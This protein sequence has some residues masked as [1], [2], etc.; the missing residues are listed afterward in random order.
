MVLVAGCAT[1]VGPVPGGAPVDRADGVRA[2]SEAGGPA[3]RAGVAFEDEPYYHA[4]PLYGVVLRDADE[5]LPVFAS[6]DGDHGFL[7]YLPP[8]GG[9]ITGT[10]RERVVEHTRYVEVL[11]PDGPGSGWVDSRYLTEWVSPDRFCRATAEEQHVEETLFTLERALAS[12][13]GA[14]L[15]DVASPRGLFVR[16]RDDAEAALLS[17]HDMRAGTLEDGMT[18]ELL[19]LLGDGDAEGHCNRVVAGGSTGA[20]FPTGYINFNFLTLHTESDEGAISWLVVFEHVD[21][22]PKLVALERLR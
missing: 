21:G 1:E 19:E 10:G 16:G 5:P 2:P 12:D 4:E 18:A 11:L 14:S 3:A 15:A 20:S 6:P 13:D 22:R 8:V 17:D 9:E 7:G